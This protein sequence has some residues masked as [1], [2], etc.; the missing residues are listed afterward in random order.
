MEGHV[1]YGHAVA[2]EAAEQEQDRR[3]RRGR[4]RS[5][6]GAARK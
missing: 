5:R 2:E 3:H 1:A 4:G 6:E